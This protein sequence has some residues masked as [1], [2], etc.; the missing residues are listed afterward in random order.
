[1]MDA[2][3]MSRCLKIARTKMRNILN[4]FSP[5]RYAPEVVKANQDLWIKKAEDAFDVVTE[6]SVDL[7]EFVSPAE[8]QEMFKSNES[9][10][11]ELAKFVSS[12]NITVLSDVPQ[13]P[14]VTNS[15]VSENQT[16]FVHV[17]VTTNPGNDEN[18]LK[19]N[20]IREEDYD[21]QSQCLEAEP[22][23]SI[24][25]S[26]KNLLLHKCSKEAANEVKEEHHRS[27]GEEKEVQFSVVL[28]DLFKLTSVDQRFRH[29]LFNYVTLMAIL[30]G[31]PI[32]EMHVVLQMSSGSIQR[33]LSCSTFDYF[34]LLMSRYVDS[35][36]YIQSVSTNANPSL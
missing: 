27:L 10:M 33:R 30:L 19:A 15:D 3:K 20:E 26:I 31:F 35:M 36:S 9:L 28:Q 8:A 11:D 25:D 12:I 18:V 17:Q 22:R 13:L 16:K 6:L 1:M 24:P 21:E 14:D 5:S 2:K 32:Q 23:G 4:V 34:Q 29:H 7:E